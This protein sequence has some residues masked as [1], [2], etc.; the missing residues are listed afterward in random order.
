MIENKLQQAV[1]DALKNLYNIEAEAPESV[2][3]Q[4]YQE[5]IFRVTI[6][7]WCSPM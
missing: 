2:V 3:L 1:S 7:L 5:R 4:D 6:P